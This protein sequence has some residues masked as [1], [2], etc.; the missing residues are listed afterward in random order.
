MT[1]HIAC[2]PLE[3]KF[4]IRNA[5]Y[6]VARWQ[7]GP[8]IVLAKPGMTLAAV[9]GAGAAGNAALQQLMLDVKDSWDQ[10]LHS[11]RL[12]PGMRL[13][14]QQQESAKQQQP[15]QVSMAEDAFAVAAA[16]AEAT[17]GAVTSSEAAAAAAAGSD[18]VNQVQRVQFSTQLRLEFGQSVAVLGNC[19]SLG[20][21]QAGSA[22]R[23][24]WSEGHKWSG[25]ADLS[26]G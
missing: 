8:N 3:Y 11:Q 10:S 23:L 22:V 12:L 17:E 4:I 13:Q 5:D 18:V 25:T 19:S 14:Q 20:D 15:Q 24:Q 1:S 16:A 6:S 7:D 26:A 9:A 2:S 21:W